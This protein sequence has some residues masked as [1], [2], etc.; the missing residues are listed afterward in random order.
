MLRPKKDSV[1][2][3][4]SL[5]GAFNRI[6]RLL[7]GAI[8]SRSTSLRLVV[9]IALAL[10][11]SSGAVILSIRSRRF[12]LSD[13]FAAA[14]P[15][16][17][18]IE[19]PCAPP[20]YT[21][22]R[23]CVD[24][25]TKNATIGGTGKCKNVFIDT[26]YTAK[27][28]NPL[29]TITID[30]G[31]VL[32]L[33]DRT[34]QLPLAIDTAGITVGGTLEIGNA[35][36]PIGTIN[37]GTEVTINFTGKRPCPSSDTCAG[38]SK[39]IQV[40]SGGSLRMFGAK[41]VPS[42]GGIS[43]TAL[44]MPA[45]TP[46]AGAKKAPPPLEKGN[47]VL[48]LADDVT[49]ITPLSGHPPGKP[50][51]AGDWIVVGTTSFNPFE[52]EFAQ[53]LTVEPNP[54]T[55]GSKVTLKEPLKYYHFGSPSPSTGTTGACKDA[56]GNKVRD[57][58]CDDATKNYGVDERAEVGLISRYIKLT[59]E[60]PR[61]DSNSLHWGGE[62][63]IHLGYNEAS[64]QG[65]EIEKFGKD[66]L[67]S[68]PIHFHMAG[69]VSKK[70][71]LIDANSIHHSYNKCITV[72]ETQNLTVQ[73][74]V[75][76]RVVGQLFYEETGSEE[77]ITFLNNLGLGAMSN[78]FDIYGITMLPPNPIKVTRQELIDKYWWTGDYLTN[79][80]PSSLS[81]NPAFPAP[82]GYDGF[83]I[84]NTDNESNPVHGLCQKPNTNNQG[85]FG[86]TRDPQAPV[87]GEIIPCQSGGTCSFS[88]RRIFRTAPYLSFILCP[89]TASGSP[90]RPPTLAAI[91]SADA[92]A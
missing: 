7:A 37:P 38:F 11:I 56:D 86:R 6:R 5:T 44:E 83:N 52:T 68:Y 91:R 89:P 22:L 26:S 2:T 72:H 60:V 20:A 84:P 32:K 75:C 78:S 39:G 13:S 87:K 35:K 16:V 31:G 17:D 82:N 92:R 63:M 65:V 88:P 36:C 51:R 90:I 14:A 62:I 76:A 66:Q 33:E 41:G 79:N 77:N 40:M 61:G 29:G 30:A 43:W 23:Q 80:V 85:G 50:W 3:M 81:F 42:L 28:G 19:D 8:A 24:P 46:V 53:I 70:V 45:G 64:I 21:P 1:I 9:W 47:Q 59:S 73:N 4:L 12:S 55:K 67:G 27:T 69:D 57:S 74:N 54:S 49:K 18:L 25:A 10:V 15:D 48:E 58:Y 34:A 71:T